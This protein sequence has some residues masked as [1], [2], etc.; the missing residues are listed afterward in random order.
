MTSL[1]R[2]IPRKHLAPKTQRRCRMTTL[3]VETTRHVTGLFVV[4]ARRW[5]GLLI[6]SKM[7]RWKIVVENRTS[8][9]DV[10]RKDDTIFIKRLYLY[11]L[12]LNVL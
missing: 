12:L 9:S 6:Y 11:M 8:G 1:T 4:I 5:D 7:Q 2:S 3:D 10:E